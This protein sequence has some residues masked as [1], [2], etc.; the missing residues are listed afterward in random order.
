MWGPAR[1]CG[2]R[3]SRSEGCA[4]KRHTLGSG[5]LGHPVAD[6]RASAGGD[7]R[8]K[9]R[10]DVGGGA[11]RGLRK[12]AVQII[13]IDDRAGVGEVP[14]E[15]LC[16]SVVGHAVP[17][18]QESQGWRDR[19]PF[20]D[21]ASPALGL[22]ETYVE[23]QGILM[24]DQGIPFGQSFDVRTAGNAGECEP[25]RQVGPWHE[26]CHAAKPREKVGLGLCSQDKGRCGEDEGCD[27]SVVGMV[28]R[29]EIGDERS[30]GFAAHCD[31]EIREEGA[32]A[33]KDPDRV[34]YVVEGA[35]RMTA[36]SFRAPVAP[37]VGQHHPDP[38]TSER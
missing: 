15:F 10:G 9:E 21:S 14:E 22:E 19:G 36:T 17:A 13:R 27:R 29:C 23:S 25:D 28:G 31:G 24:V 20:R 35:I 32:G 8:A 26:S 6:G 4:F 33:S 5:G 3:V 2:I 34:A 38:V 37:E 11:G 18:T 30:V 12:D 1:P 7:D 16:L